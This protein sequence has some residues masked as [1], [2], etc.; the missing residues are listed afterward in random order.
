[1]KKVVKNFTTSKAVVIDN[2]ES[3]EKLTLTNFTYDKEAINDIT[4]NIYN[5]FGVNENVVKGDYTEQQFS[6]FYNNTIEPQ[7]QR[8]QE[9]LQRKLIEKKDFINGERLE[10]AKTRIIAT[11]SQFINSFDKLVYH[12]VTSVNDLLI[13]L[14]MDGF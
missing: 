2:D 14:V 11:I 6:A 3:I 7:A 1:M 10:V 9:E 12:G 13:I 8:F 4:K 5:F